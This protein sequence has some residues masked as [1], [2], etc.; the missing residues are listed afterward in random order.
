METFFVFIGVVTLVVIVIFVLCTAGL[1][2]WEAF[3]TKLAH[4]RDWR[5]NSDNKK[6][7]EDLNF[8]YGLLESLV[9]TSIDFHGEE[10]EG[11]ETPQELIEFLNAKIAEA[12]TRGEAEDEAPISS[13]RTTGE[14]Q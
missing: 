7:R 4:K 6:L 1:A 2:V 10:A 12:E 9:D 5:V 14:G 3:T 8:A 11:I 13:V